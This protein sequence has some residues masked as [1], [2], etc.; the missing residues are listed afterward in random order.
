MLD[1]VTRFIGTA[2]KAGNSAI[3]VA[4]ESHRNR[5]LPQLQTYGLDMDA[6]IEQ[7]RYVA[8]DAAET[9]SQLLLNGPDPGRFL[10]LLGNLVVTGME[11]AKAA[12]P[13]L[14]CSENA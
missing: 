8:L 3:V 6:V 7:G 5:L 2:L 10:E 1:A 13:R 4:T 9:L 12:H 11:A 14:A